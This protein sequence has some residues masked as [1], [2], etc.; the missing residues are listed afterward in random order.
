MG[1]WGYSLYFV[2]WIPFWAGRILCLLYRCKEALLV[3]HFFE[4]IRFYAVLFFSFSN[5]T[6]LSSEQAYL[7]TLRR[8]LHKPFLVDLFGVNPGKMFYNELRI[9]AGIVEALPKT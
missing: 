9:W 3:P 6:L 7:W 2:M 4:K 8:A 1:Y 5:V